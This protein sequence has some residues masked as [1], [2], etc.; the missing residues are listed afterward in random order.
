MIALAGSMLMM[1]MTSILMSP[2]K[3]GDLLASAVGDPFHVPGTNFQKPKT[4][5]REEI[6]SAI[7]QFVADNNPDEAKKLYNELL[8]YQSI[9]GL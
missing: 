5:N 2:I 9:H 1:L 8:K 6:L 4:E 7:Q 3:G